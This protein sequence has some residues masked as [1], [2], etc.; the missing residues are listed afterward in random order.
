M[1]APSPVQAPRPGF[2]PD[3]PTM[4]SWVARGAAV[5]AL[6]KTAE[7]F[8]L[9]IHPGTTDA[10]LNTFQSVDWSAVYNAAQVIGGAGI[11][12]GFRRLG[13]QLLNALRNPT[14]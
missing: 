5:V 14:I 4:Q 1:S 9:G 13:G 2:L 10:V 11:A 8:G 12:L 3:K 6:A 7:A